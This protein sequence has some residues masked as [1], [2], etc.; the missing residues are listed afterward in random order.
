MSTRAE[1]VAA[2]A[3][4]GGS[5][6]SPRHPAHLADLAKENAK[7]RALTDEPFTGPTV[8]TW[9][10]GSCAPPSPPSIRRQGGLRRGQRARHR[11]DLPFA[12]Q[13]GSGGERCGVA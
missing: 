9:A 4:S 6:S 3:N 11:A 7:W 1:L 5:A 2:V 8:S 13:H 10:R 12:A